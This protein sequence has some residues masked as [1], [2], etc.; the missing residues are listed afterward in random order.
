MPVPRNFVGTFIVYMMDGAG[1]DHERDGGGGR[2]AVREQHQHLP[3]RGG[4][5]GQGGGQGLGGH[6][7]LLQPL[8]RPGRREGALH[9]QGARGLSDTNY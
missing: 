2:E 9:L 5:A 8:R 1:G 4:G 6:L 3:S 7:R